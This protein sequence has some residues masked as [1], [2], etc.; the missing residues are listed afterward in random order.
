MGKNNL[1]VLTEDNELTGD[2]EFTGETT[3]SNTS[4]VVI[5]SNLPTTDPEVAGQLWSNSNVL[6]VSAGS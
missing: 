6:T 2:N 3:F 4:G 5:M 1:A